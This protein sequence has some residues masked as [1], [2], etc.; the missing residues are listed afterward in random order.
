M[1]TRKHSVGAAESNT[2]RGSPIFKT[3]AN[4]SI[5]ISL[6]KCADS[7]DW[8]VGRSLDKLADNMIRQETGFEIRLECSNS[9]TVRDEKQA[10][11]MGDGGVGVM[12][13]IDD[14]MYQR[15]C[16][17]SICPL[18]EPNAMTFVH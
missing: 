18:P 4:L 7:V 16:F 9:V 5:N 2:A 6:E 10:G 12:I 8:V 15:P 17:C 13:Y 11:Q 14:K 3:W 1:E